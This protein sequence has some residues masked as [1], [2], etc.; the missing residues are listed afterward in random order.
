MV[1][2][3]TPPDVKLGTI[4]GGCAMQSIADG[5]TVFGLAAMSLDRPDPR[6]VTIPVTFLPHGVTPSPE[7]PDLL[8]LFEKHGPGC[9]AVDLASREV[10]AVLAAP[11]GRQF[12]GHGAFSLD[13]SLLYC[14]QTDLAARQRGHIAV[15][16]GRDLRY[17]GDFPSHGLS[18]HDCALRDDGRTLVITNGGSSAGVSDDPP[19]VTFVDVNTGAL[20]ARE[21]IP[22]P[23]LNAGHLAMTLGDGLAVVS[24]PRDGLAPGS[25]G[26]VS[27]RGPRGS[28]R[29]C[30]E[31][32]E[33]VNLM[34]G[35]TLSV[36]IGGPHDVVATTSPIGQVV[37]F[38]SLATGE[39][40][41]SL[42]VPNPRG[43][44]MT[45]DGREFLITFGAT[46]KV[47]RVDTGTLRPVDVPGNRRGIP[48][49][50]TGSHV[51]VHE[52]AAVD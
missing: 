9:C 20:L 17:L 39:L 29:T 7:R 35:E 6:P 44:A 8:L 45:L 3:A 5:S 40:L 24:A 18:P 27:L 38:W 43:V 32:A 19:C 16:D 30:V 22:D 1:D 26:G 37:A 10:A 31:P 49:A 28:L 36:A 21:T 34:V 52:T 51:R 23:R 11:R 14:T 25:R 41:G 50:I 15:H 4:L 2:R 12:Y 33:V 13:G 47:A 42:R 48:C 46:A